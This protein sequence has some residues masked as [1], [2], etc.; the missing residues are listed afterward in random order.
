MKTK[1][2]YVKL[3]H[4]ALIFFLVLNSSS[5]NAQL[6]INTSFEGTNPWAG[7]DNGQHCCS[8]SVTQSSTIYHDGT[9]SFRAEVRAGDP[10]VSSGWRA[11]LVPNY[12]GGDDG[13]MWYGFSVYF[14]T[15]VNSAGNWTGSY[16][17]HF[18]QWHPDNSS[19]SLVFGLWGS[20]GEWDLTVNQQGDET[21]D[22]YFRGG[23]TPNGGTHVKIVANVWH[24]VVLHVNWTTGVTQF[25][26][27]GVIQNDLV[28]PWS[29]GPGRYLKFGMNRWGNCNGGAPCDT[30]VIYYDNLKIGR[31]V[32]YSDVAP[33]STTPPT[34]AANT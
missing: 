18:I 16:G 28:I 15:P 31:N 19:G 33:S 10:A 20:N 12:P 21:A 24:N 14:E 32:T 26:L 4:F 29:T 30:W 17:G 8:Y 34:P 13:D 11:E 27:N 1:T 25:W 7:F 3:L 22:H 9:K 5:L 2:A 23:T 6:L